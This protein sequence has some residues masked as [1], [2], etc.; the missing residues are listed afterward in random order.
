VAVALA[1]G[2]LLKLDFAAVLG[3]LSG[4]TTNTPSL[5]AAQQTLATIPG[6]SDDRLALPALAYAVTYPGAI[7]GIIGT[8]LVLKRVFR[9]DAEREATAFAAEQRGR[10]E[11]LENR[12]LVVENQ[13]LPGV[14]IR[15]SCAETGV[16]VSRHR[17]AGGN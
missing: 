16:T 7:V 8:L 9:I 2:W 6:V 5:G 11:L 13:T 12:T 17:H 4:A 1:L 3:L 10:V 15:H 14:A